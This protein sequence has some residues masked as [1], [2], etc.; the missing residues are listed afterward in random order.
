MNIVHS[1]YW[2]RQSAKFYERATQRPQDYQ[3][4]LAMASRIQAEVGIQNVPSMEY[5]MDKLAP[6]EERRAFDR[7]CAKARKYD[8]A[9]AYVIQ[10][11]STWADA[12]EQYKK[13]EDFSKDAASRLDSCHGIKVKPSSVT[14]WLKANRLKRPRRS[15]KLPI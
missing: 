3:R 6:P 9:Q 13:I 7:A 4:A 5:L 14:Q 1:R 2:A 12:P 11:H 8:F 10:F 15:N